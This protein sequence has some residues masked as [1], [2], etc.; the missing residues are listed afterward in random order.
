MTRGKP[1]EN[2]MDI[3]KNITSCNRGREN[4]ISNTET[5]YQQKNE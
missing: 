3:G 5:L 1:K 4:K 2:K